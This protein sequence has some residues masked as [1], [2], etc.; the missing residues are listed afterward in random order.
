MLATSYRVLSRADLWLEWTG[1]IPP[2]LADVA[3]L[4][5]QGR[6]ALNDAYLVAEK[7]AYQK[8]RAAFAAALERCQDRSALMWFLACEYAE[9]GYFADSAAL[10]GALLASGSTRLDVQRLYAE[11]TWWRDQGRWLPWIH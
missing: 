3:G 1:E 10:L 11:M 2:E 4:I 7:G 8:A 9:K 6:D 5:E